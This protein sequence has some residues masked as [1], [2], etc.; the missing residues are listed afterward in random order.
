MTDWIVILDGGRFDGERRS[1]IR[2]SDLAD[3]PTT[4]RAFECPCCGRCAVPLPGGAAERA[5][6]DVGALWWRYRLTQV[7]G[8]ARVAVYGIPRDDEL[9]E[10]GRVGDEVATPD[11][12]GAMA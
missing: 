8:L 9:A 10:P 5:L 11:L 3:P 4:V 7:F 2:S 12:I 1:I 6:D